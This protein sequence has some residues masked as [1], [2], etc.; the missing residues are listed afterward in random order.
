PQQRSWRSLRWRWRSASQGPGGPGSVGWIDTSI[1][2]AVAVDAGVEATLL[3]AQDI[4]LALLGIEEAGADSVSAVGQA[5]AG[6]GHRQHV[7]FVA[8]PRAGATRPAVAAM[9]RTRT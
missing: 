5:G 3:D 2:P 1:R 4:A 8:L 6:L 9:W 7:A